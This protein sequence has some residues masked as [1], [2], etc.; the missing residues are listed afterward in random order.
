M[1][2]QGPWVTK[3]ILE[4]EERVAELTEEIGH[5]E[6][7]LIKRGQMLREIVNITKGPP[8]ENSWHSTHDAVESVERLQ[9]RVAAQQSALNSI[10]T[11]SWGA[12]EFFDV[13]KAA[14]WMQKI[15][16]DALDEVPST[17]AFI[18]RKQAAAVE[19]EIVDL[20]SELRKS[21][22]RGISVKELLHESVSRSSRIR[23][24]AKKFDD[25]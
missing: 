2:D 17:E 5:L 4:L 25:Q 11:C 14:S 21:G 7:S 10:C 19:S 24:E 3:T 20:C 15:A 22:Y 9:S 16:Y 13:G 1:S 18:L 23:K 6:D 8:E 12:A